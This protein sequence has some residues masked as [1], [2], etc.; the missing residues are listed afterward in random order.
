MRLLL[1]TETS[2]TLAFACRVYTESSQGLFQSEKFIKYLVSNQ[3]Q[4]QFSDCNVLLFD[5]FRHLGLLEIDNKW[6]YLHGVM[7]WMNIVVFEK[8][9]YER[10]YDFEIHC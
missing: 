2:W 1:Y 7:L 6:L 5:T 4:V 8:L 10:V 9:N 3:K